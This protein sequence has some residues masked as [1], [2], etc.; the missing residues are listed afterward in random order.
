MKSGI[1]KKVIIAEIILF[2]ALSGIMFNGNTFS[3]EEVD[4]KVGESFKEYI[5]AECEFQLTGEEADAFLY[6]AALDSGETI[7]ANAAYRK[8]LGK[9]N[10]TKITYEIADSDGKAEVTRVN[11]AEFLG[12]M[13]MI[14]AAGDLA[15]WFI[16]SWRRGT[17]GEQRVFGRSRKKKEEKAKKDKYKAQGPTL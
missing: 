8:L 11:V 4:I 17:L 7:R 3:R 12:N 6:E 16:I 14:V 5:G 1:W 10:I 13:A 2:I 15:A 9:Y